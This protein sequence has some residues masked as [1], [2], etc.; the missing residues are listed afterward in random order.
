MIWLVN[1]FTFLGLLF[2]FDY[3]G[4]RA[5]KRRRMQR[6]EEE[7]CG[8]LNELALFPAPFNEGDEVSKNLPSTQS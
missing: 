4:V 3:Q 5:L 7:K 2:L 1:F 6:L 8:D